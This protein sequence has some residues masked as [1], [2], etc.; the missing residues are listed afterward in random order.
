MIETPII[1][2][3]RKKMD[4]IRNSLKVNTIFQT[5]TIKAEEISQKRISKKCRKNSNFSV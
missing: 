5:N 2:Q 3:Q 1:S 4:H